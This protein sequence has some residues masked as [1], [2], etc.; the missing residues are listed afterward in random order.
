MGKTHPSVVIWHVFPS[1]VMTRYE[2]GVLQIRQ[3][4]AFFETSNFTPERLGGAFF[5]CFFFGQA[6]YLVVL[7][8]RGVF[9]D[10]RPLCCSERVEGKLPSP[11]NFST[12]LVRIESFSSWGRIINRLKKTNM[13]PKN[14]WLEDELSF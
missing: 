1:V 2:L 8:F 9:Q 3:S 11:R 4:N 13:S 5:C 12:L 10:Q 7:L 14:Q 6:Y